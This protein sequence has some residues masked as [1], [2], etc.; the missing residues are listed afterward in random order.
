M[1]TYSRLL[2]EYHVVLVDYDTYN[3]VL[4]RTVGQILQSLYSTTVLPTESSCRLQYRLHYTVQSS[5]EPNTGNERY[6]AHKNLCSQI[7]F[8]REKL[9]KQHPKNCSLGIIIIYKKYSNL[10]NIR[11]DV[12]Q[13][14]PTK[15]REPQRQQHAR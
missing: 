14:Q 1:I 3:T 12:N 2:P 9:S 7:Y 15:K 13:F 10:E 11:Y 5:F 6:F 4:V 8:N